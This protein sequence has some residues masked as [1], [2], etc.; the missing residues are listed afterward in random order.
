MMGIGARWGANA[1]MFHAALR[2]TGAAMF[3]TA[4]TMKIF[5]FPAGMPLDGRPVELLTQIGI[6]GLLETFGGL[7]ILIGFLT[8]PTAFILSGEMAVAF[9][10]FHFP[11]HY[12]PTLSGG[13]GSVLYCFIWL[14]FSAAGAGP[15][16]VDSFIARHRQKSRRATPAQSAAGG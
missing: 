15:L 8:R 9:F 3:M 13:V 6:G 11:Q 7:L 2:I 16:S 10:Q 5:A 12:W 4:G 1:P 14:Y